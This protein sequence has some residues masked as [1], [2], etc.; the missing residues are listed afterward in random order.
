MKTALLTGSNLGD[1]LAQLNQAKILVSKDIGE[2]LI[3]SP[4]YVTSAWGKRDQPDFLNQALLIETALT[5]QELLS[6]V[7]SIENQ[8]GR[9]RNEKW[10]SRLIDIDILTYENK[11]IME[12]NLSIPPPVLP[13]RRFSL[14]PLN[15]ILPNWK[16]PIY[17]KTAL[18]LLE[19]CEDKELVQVYEQ[20]K[21]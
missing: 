2:I 15:Y 12:E 13:Q 5:P 7:L 1:S 4:I 6:M 18:E 19:E 20:I 10:E 11:F 3:E 9:V 16:H 8:M 17:N 14:I 21:S